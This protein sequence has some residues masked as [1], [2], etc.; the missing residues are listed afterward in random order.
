MKKK[1]IIIALPG[2]FFLPQAIN[3]YLIVFIRAIRVISGKKH[4]T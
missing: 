2:L 4:H 1:I 3:L